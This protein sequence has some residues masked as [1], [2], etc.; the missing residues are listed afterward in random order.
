L[1]VIIVGIRLKLHILLTKLI[2]FYLQN[3]EI[4]PRPIMQRPP[5]ATGGTFRNNPPIARPIPQHIVISS[6]TLR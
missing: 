4:T 3:T 6:P 2:Q 5:Y 1:F